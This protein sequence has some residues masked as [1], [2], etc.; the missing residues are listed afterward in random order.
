[1]E[2]GEDKFPSDAYRLNVGK[3]Q[4]SL[5]GLA[6]LGGGATLSKKQKGQ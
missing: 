4:M 1:M 5:T 6:Q 3:I 2:R